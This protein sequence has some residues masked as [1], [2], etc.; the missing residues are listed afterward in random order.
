MVFLI[1]WLVTGT[2]AAMATILVQSLWYDS[3]I[4]TDQETAREFLKC[5]GLA[6]FW[7]IAIVWFTYRVIHKAVKG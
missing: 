7:P 4:L 2:L 6:F 5:V 1:I 3:L